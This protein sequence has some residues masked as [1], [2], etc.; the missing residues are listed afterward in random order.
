[1]LTTRRSALLPIA[2]SLAL[3]LSACGGG[4]TAGTAPSDAAVDGTT[5]DRATDDG[6]D[7][8]LDAEVADEVAEDADQ[9]DVEGPGGEATSGP[10]GTVQVDGVDY[11]LTEFRRCEPLQDG[12]I[13]REL[14]LQGIGEA[15]GDRIQIDVYVETI[16][17]LPFN[18]VSWAG[19]EGVFGG[20]EDA[21]IEIV[22]DQVSGSA[23]LLDAMSQ[24][25]TLDIRFDLPIPADEIAC[26]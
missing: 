8:A 5:D 22:D 4:D 19:P 3:L 12:T 11:V 20:P 2:I 26:R 23:T 10:S 17:N 9:D 25:E 24:T 16:G 15:D 6:S 18:D 7:E 14:E 21:E 1:M 13:D